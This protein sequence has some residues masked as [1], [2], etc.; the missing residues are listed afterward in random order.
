[1]LQPIRATCLFLA[2]FVLAVPAA[3]QDA[4]AGW[5]Q[6]TIADVEFAH[7]LLAE[8]HP[9]AVPEIADTGFT[10]AL[11]EAR[12]VGLERAA[13]VTDWN[14]Y[15]AVMRG[16]A[17]AMADKHIWMNP[18]LSP[19]AFRWAGAVVSLRGTRWQITGGDSTV[20]DVPIG[21]VLESCD[22][23]PIEAFAERRLGSSHAVWGVEAQRVAAAPFL[24]IDE[25]DPFVAMPSTC[26]VVRDG[27]RE[28]WTPAWRAISRT[29]LASFLQGAVPTGAPG[30]RVREWRGGLWIAMQSL[31]ARAGAVVDTV[32]GMPDRLRAARTIVVDVRGNE[33]GNSRY[34]L[35][36]AN[37]IYGPAYVRAVRDG[38]ES[39][40]GEGCH[41]LFRASP[42]NL[43]AWT[44]LVERWRAAGDSNA[45][46]AFG[47]A[48]GEMQAALS[49]GRALT[50]SACPPSDRP[51]VREPPPISD[52]VQSLSRYQGKVVLLTDHAC[53]SSCLLLT[54]LFRALGAVQVGEATDANTHYMEVR[55]AELPSGL[56]RFS[57]LQKVAL[58]AP[59]EIGPFRPAHRF[60][61][62]I[63]DTAALEGWLAMLADAS[64]LSSR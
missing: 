32:A 53:F 28:T 2:V 12:R 19:K 31:D 7:R 18:S 57:V 30:F 46:A 16:M 42:G 39:G 47:P 4:A 24:L 34:G 10:R 60:D 44:A 1:M 5:R 52:A 49:E 36:L 6:L 35:D 14:G 37:A 63:A 50:G 15:L 48:I 9:G 51:A 58:A 26:V 56:G 38:F 64:R 62:D 43:A 27:T 54:Q 17:Y 59:R 61:G 25:G 40:A 41:T 55:E 11:A 20:G 29:A 22:G 23:E 8:N 45:V 21:A 33:G 3:A 13:R